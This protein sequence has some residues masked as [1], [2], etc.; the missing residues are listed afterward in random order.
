MEATGTIWLSHWVKGIFPCLFLFY[1]LKFFGG[2]PIVQTVLDVD[3]PELRASRNSRYE[4]VDLI[5]SDLDKAIEYLPNEQNIPSEDKGRISKG[6][7]EAFKARVLLYEA[8]WRKY[9][10]TSTDFEGSAGPQSDQVNAFWKRLLRCV[11]R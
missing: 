5:L 10:G 1:L 7:A 4:V 11:M 3:S 9:N 2:V 6:G 8:T